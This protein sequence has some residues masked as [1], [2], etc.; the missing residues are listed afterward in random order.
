MLPNAK[1]YE[2]L[3]AQFRWRIPERFNIGRDCADKWADGSGRLAILHKQA[4]GALVPHS[5]D[6]LKKESNRLANALAAQGVEPG[7]RVAVLLAQRPETA[8]AHIAAYKLGA[9]AVP[10]FVLFG[11]EALSFRLRDS[12]AKALITDAEGLEKIEPLRADLPDLTCLVSLSGGGE[13]VLGYADVIQRASDAFEPLDTGPD[14]PAVIIYTSGT[15]GSPKG[16]LHG[17]RVLLGHLPGVEMP[18]ELFPKPG[19]LFWTP[20]DWAWIGGLFDVLLPSLHHGVPVLAHRFA[21]FDPEAAFALM[22][23]AGV[24]N[25]FLPPTALKMLRQVE[26]PAERHAYRL[27]SIGSG[28]ETLGEGLLEWGRET[29][30]LTVNEFYGQTECNLVLSNCSGVMPVKPGSMGRAVPCHDVAVVDDAGERL[31]PG[32]EG[33]I[34]VRRPDPVMFLRYWNNPEATEKKF[35]GD[36]LVTGDRGRIDEEGYFSFV[37]RDDDVITSAGY[38]I[39]PGEIEDCLLGHPA[40]RLA[41][42]VGVPDPVRTE[43]VKA[44]L[45]LNEGFEPSEKLAAE[46]QDWVKTRLAAYEYPREVAFLESL[47]MTAT[48]KIMRRELRDR[49][50]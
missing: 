15:T 40:V 32:E 14:D 35:R 34:A 50:S 26:R 3:Q 13:G 11:P 37:G 9:I 46:I 27:R 22:A 17:H 47:P 21:K 20:A 1:T 23:E 45:V 41:A 4:D 48:G 31:R 2:A 19:D 12:G 5:F 36:W 43:R 10:L 38:R 6:W 24:R 33:D 44:F 39:G 29:F 7:D 49:E 30:G 16:A 28:G 18:Q 8:V 25:A 42:A